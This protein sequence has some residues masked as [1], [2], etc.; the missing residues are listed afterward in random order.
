MQAVDAEFVG[1]EKHVGQL[2]RLNDRAAHAGRDFPPAVEFPKGEPEPF[3]V[4]VK[5][6]PLDE[7][8]RGIVGVFLGE[9][10]EVFGVLA[11][12]QIPLNRRF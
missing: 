5:N 8:G 1:H 11:K 7:S 12:G 4:L 9:F 10:F 2:E 6:R 3:D